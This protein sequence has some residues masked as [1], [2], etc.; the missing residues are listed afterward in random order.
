MAKLLSIF[1]IKLDK[2]TL[3]CYENWKKN[4]PL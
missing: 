1:I 3:E 4:N 2:I